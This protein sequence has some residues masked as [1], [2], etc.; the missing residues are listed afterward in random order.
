MATL[1]L[2]LDD[3]SLKE[4]AAHVRIRIAHK[5]TQA[6]IGT[7]VYVEPK[8]FT[9]DLH[10]PIL[11]KAQRW[12]EKTEQI[13]SI[14]RKLEE[15]LFDLGRSGVLDD[16]TA[17]EIKEYICGKKRTKSK[18]LPFTKFMS[19][20]GETRPAEKTRE[21]YQ[22][23]LS[24]LSAFCHSTNKRQELF[25]EDIDYKFLRE[26]DNWMIANKKGISTRGVVMRNI[27]A[28][29]NE[30]M[31]IG[32]AKFD[33]Y[34][35]RMFSI[36][37]KGLAEIVYLSREDMQKLLN[38]KNLTPALERSRDIFMISFYLCGMNLVDIYSLP[39]FAKNEIVFVRNK[40]AH[41]EPKPTH[42]RIEPELA[43]LIEKYRGNKY[44][45]SF[46]EEFRQFKTFQQNLR[47]RFTTLSALIGGAHI[48]LAIARHTWATLACKCG[49]EEYV[50][51][52]SLGHV[53]NDVTARHYIEYDWD[54]T[55][56]ANR[57]VIDY[58][59]DAGSPQSY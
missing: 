7:K 50:I 15:T 37:R 23:A 28:T 8:Y 29:Y 26:F 52:K 20:F 43:T 14:V 24:V 41:R 13:E 46:A 44:L 39:K 33:S 32:Y 9:N 16:M 25:F 49:V 2:R 12:K 59:Q 53:D 47:H 30:A 54:R 58:V 48:T 38:L 18:I 57:K 56:K 42:I 11:S 17:P 21:M 27:R 10:C 22:Y 45:F 51:S 4:G 3:R 31:K 36:K 6:Y 5:N 34:P 55:A 19:E 35:F 40:I 1:I